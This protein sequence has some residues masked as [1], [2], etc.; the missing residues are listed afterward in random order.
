[1]TGIVPPDPRVILVVEDEAANRVL[2]R[3]ILQRAEDEIV[4]SATVVEATDL[5]SA[6]AVVAGRAVDLVL[7]DVRL[8]DGSGLS[9]AEELRA[10]DGIDRPRVIVLSASVLPEEREA[11]LASGADLFFSKPYP[12]ATLSEAIRGVLVTRVESLA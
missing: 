2:L 1:M 9:L 12:A 8:P 5:A 7:L 6:R 11:A 4:R 10:R 3:A